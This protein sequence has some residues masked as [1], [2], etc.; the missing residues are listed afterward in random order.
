MLLATPTFGE[1]P[2]VYLYVLVVRLIL[3]C[4]VGVVIYFGI[5]LYKRKWSRSR[6]VAVLILLLGGIAPLIGYAD[7]SELLFRLRY[8]SSPLAV[9]RFVID[10]M[11]TVEVEATLGKPHSRLVYVNGEQLWSYYKDSYG[12]RLYTVRFGT[13]G[14][15]RDCPNEWNLRR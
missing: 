13:D 14:K 1:V 4:L 5:R 12:D 3:C 6:T 2:V 9:N 7:P 15:S 10:G 11:T 8:S